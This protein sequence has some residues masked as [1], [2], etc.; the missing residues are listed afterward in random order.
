MKKFLSTV[1]AFILSLFGIVAPSDD[2]LPIAERE[3][4]PTQENIQLFTEIFETETKW[5]ASL[6]L[7]NG[8]IPMNYYAN[9]ELRMNPY[10]ADFAALALLDKAD[11]Y[12]DEVKKIVFD[13]T[14]TLTTGKFEVSEIKVIDDNY[15]QNQILYK[16][17]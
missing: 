8:A 15:T 10:F 7:D 13:K 6:Q 16:P 17:S 14:G 3:G 1:L 5:L 2:L 11:E 9:G 12:A 4:V